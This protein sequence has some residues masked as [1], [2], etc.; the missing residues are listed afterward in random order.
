M[1]AKLLALIELIPKLLDFLKLAWGRFETALRNQ[2][3]ERR[4]K[5]LA[6]ALEKANATDDT[7]AL[8]RHFDPHRTYP[9]KP[10]PKRE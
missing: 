4:R 9:R 7:R 6:E 2:A 1:W 8:E 10:D 3:E 5:R